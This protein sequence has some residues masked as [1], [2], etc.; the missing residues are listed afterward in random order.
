MINCII[1]AAK[2]QNNGA[3]AESNYDSPM[4]LR[5]LNSHN[6][7]VSELKSRTHRFFRILPLLLI[8]VSF[9]SGLIHAAKPAN[10][11]GGT[12]DSPDFAFPKSVS[13][14]AAGVYKKALKSGDAAVAIK[15]AIELDIADALVS[16]SAFSANAARFAELSNMLPVGYSAIG[17][18]LEARLYSDLYSANSYKFDRLTLPEGDTP[19]NVMEWSRGLILGKI[20]ELV[21][22]AVR[23]RPQLELMPIS[24][25][26]SVIIDPADAIKADF[27]LFDFA[28]YQIGLVY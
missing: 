26:K 17:Y 4:H 12:F 11:V 9:A 8:F 21:D 20:N 23:Q 7:G 25:L 6:V 14:N 15:A 2:K 10:N 24:S 22:S 3:S 5:Y 1:K 16:E 13:K 27:N 19:D 28:A 18:I